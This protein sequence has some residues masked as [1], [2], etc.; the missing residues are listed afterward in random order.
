M[1]ILINAK[2]IDVRVEKQFNSKYRLKLSETVIMGS[3]KWVI[4]IEDIEQIKESLIDHLQD[5]DNKTK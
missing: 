5:I 1:E 3:Q 2:N 4:Y